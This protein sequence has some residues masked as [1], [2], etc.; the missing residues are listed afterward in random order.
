[1]FNLKY[2][3]PAGRQL[4]TNKQAKQKASQPRSFPVLL[5]PFALIHSFHHSHLHFH[6]IA[7]Y[8]PKQFVDEIEGR[9][10]L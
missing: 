7:F 6:F 1:M 3:L 9:S 2:L 4:S 10:L 5:Q 8:L